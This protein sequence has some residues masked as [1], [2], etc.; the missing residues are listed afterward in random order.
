MR[1]IICYYKLKTFR[2]KKEK[3]ITAYNF[4]V[5]SSLTVYTMYALMN[6]ISH[7]TDTF[8]VHSCK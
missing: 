3:K 7:I 1:Y 6:S 4:H 8:N 2:K 5:S